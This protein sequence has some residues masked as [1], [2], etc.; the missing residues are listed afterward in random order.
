MFE[1]VERYL[2]NLQAKDWPGFGATISADGFERVGPFCDVVTGK[3]DYLRFV[4]DVVSTLD[5]YRVRTRRLFGSDGAVGAEIDESF[6][7]DGQP[8]T[9]PEVL[10][11][12]VGD[13]GLI[14]RVQVYLMRPGGA[15]ASSA[16]QATTGGSATP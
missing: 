8:M 1:V 13:H 4:E 11:F 7:L 5:H 9:F 3:E 15:P 14:T 6:V 2:A 10:I 16:D 12:D